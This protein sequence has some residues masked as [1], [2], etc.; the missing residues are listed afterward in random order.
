MIRNSVF[1]Q[2]ANL[3]TLSLES[4][5]SS[6]L[7]PTNIVDE[8]KSFS[9]VRQKQFIACRYLL[10]DLLHKHFTTPSLPKIIIGDN[11]RPLFEDPNLPDFNIS[12]SGN[13]VAVSLTEQGRIGLDIEQK[14]ERKN[15]LAIAKLFFSS[16]ENDWLNRQQN[17]LD[18][19]WQLWTLRES[20]LKLH[21]KGVWQMK[22]MKI[23]MPHQKITAQFGHKFYC[24][25]E[26]TEH[27]H[28]S[29]CCDNPI[30]RLTINYYNA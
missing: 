6:S 7:I 12:H 16:H 18:A 3:D 4:M 14:R 8:S 2:Y 23:A 10:V 20:A 19:F 24:H 17:S 27:I 5:L 9:R 25:Y 30:D 15:H 1:V 29:I 11:H 13:F 21:A 22:E 28:L 26:P